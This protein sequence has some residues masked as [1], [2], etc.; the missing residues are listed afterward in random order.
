MRYALSNDRTEW[1]DAAYGV[2]DWHAL[3]DTLLR[4]V[5]YI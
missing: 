2:P 3:R 5:N 4:P 1:Y